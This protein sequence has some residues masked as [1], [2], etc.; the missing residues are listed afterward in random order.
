VQNVVDKLFLKCLGE[1]IRTLRI[2]KNLTQEELGFLVGNSGK[3]IGRIERGENNVTSCMIYK[4]SLS[5]K[6]EMKE[7]FDFKIQKKKNI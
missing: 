1:H 6:I 3:Q 4:L 7:I 5:L 2:K